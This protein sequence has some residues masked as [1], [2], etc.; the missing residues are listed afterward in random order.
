MEHITGRTDFFENEQGEW[1][2]KI[3]LPLDEHQQEVILAMK[4]INAL[5]KEQR[6]L[7]LVMMMN[8][9]GITLDEYIQ[10]HEKRW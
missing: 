3:K 5:D 4:M 6:M 10:Y 8:A 9:L 2:Q 1:R 7:V